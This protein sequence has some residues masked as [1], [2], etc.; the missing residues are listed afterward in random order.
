M[1]GRADHVD[2]VGA[3][4]DWIDIGGGGGWQGKGTGR[5]RGGI[6]ESNTRCYKT[7]RLHL[8]DLPQRFADIEQCATR[9]NRRRLLG[10]LVLAKF[11]LLF[12]GA[13][14]VVETA[15]GVSGEDEEVAGD[16]KASLEV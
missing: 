8:A 13:G 2:G 9:A 10:N 5:G 3:T 16:G 14:T 4:K 11:L 15:A 12:A 6:N 7:G 1:R